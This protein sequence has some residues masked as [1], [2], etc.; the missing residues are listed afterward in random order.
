MA[1]LYK[2]IPG[3]PWLNDRYVEDIKTNDFID[4]VLVDVNDYPIF[5]DDRKY[6][7]RW[8]GNDLPDGY[9]T[10]EVVVWFNGSHK[11]NEAES[12][13]SFDKATKRN[14]LKFII[15][16]GRRYN[17]DMNDFAAALFVA[18]GNCAHKISTEIEK[19]HWVCDDAHPVTASDFKSIVSFSAAESPRRIIEAIC[20][21]RLN[22]AIAWYDHLQKEE[23]E[24]GWI[25]AYLEKFFDQ[26]TKLKEITLNNSDVTSFLTQNEIPRYR[27]E[28]EHKVVV[29]RLSLDKLR[30]SHDIFTKL[31][32]F[33][34]TGRLH[35]HQY[36][37]LAL[38]RFFEEQ[39][40]VR[41]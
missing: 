4:E 9:D 27:Y 12:I 38:M 2:V 11:P 19:L 41:S 3:E 20:E 29:H 16:E 34:K 28:N 6:L 36:V 1:K 32:G 23:A 35:S 13:P 15:E 25:L 26:C 5:T 40:H 17:I 10:F 18:A 30:S 37:S 7:L 24:T 31:Y 33:H 21:G 39:E 14:Y 22:K 8:H